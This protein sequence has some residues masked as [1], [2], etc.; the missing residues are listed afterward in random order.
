MI[1]GID[2]RTQEV[3]LSV[4]EGWPETPRVLTN[5]STAEMI[6]YTSNSVLAMLIS[7]SNEIARLCSAVGSVD[8]VDVM[9]GVHKSAYFTRRLPDG[10]TVVA[11]ITSFL[12]A[13]CGFGGSCLP[14]DV[15]ALVAQGKTYG[16]EMQLLQSVL[17]INRGQ[18]DH[19]IKL[20]DK[21][22]P[23]MGGVKVAILGLAFKP[24]TDDVRESPAFPIIS[25][26]KKRGAIIKAYDPVARP[27]E[28]PDMAGVELVETLIDAVSDV[29][30]IFIVTRWAEF[31][32]LSGV[33]RA[34]G[35]DPLVVDG[36][37]LLNP[38]GF[39][40]FEGIGR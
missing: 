1:G 13:G 20:A 40:R 15:S 29:E 31:T 11:P 14:K 17:D 38:D 32:Q 22:Y 18:P 25:M 34:L 39:R 9:N 4:Y 5:N 10:Q 3:L 35:R 6:K 7:F 36:R 37:R 21:H 24:D 12:G 23:S 28:H 26:L 19:F 30:I 8:V 2:K 27:I 33:L 16:L